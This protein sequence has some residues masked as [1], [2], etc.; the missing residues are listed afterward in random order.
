MGYHSD[1]FLSDEV[2]STVVDSAAGLSA[3]ETY[4]NAWIMKLG[5]VP[6]TVGCMEDRENTPEYE[7]YFLLQSHY[8]LVTMDRAM[9]KLAKA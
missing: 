4:A 6:M 5:L 3:K 7:L 2:I 8:D 9:N 1:D